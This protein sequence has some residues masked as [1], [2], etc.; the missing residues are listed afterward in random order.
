[1]EL[2]NGVQQECLDAGIPIEE[3]NKVSEMVENWKPKGD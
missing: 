3:A 1:M 2:I